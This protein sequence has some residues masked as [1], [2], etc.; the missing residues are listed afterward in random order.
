MDARREEL[1]V[2]LASINVVRAAMYRK[3]AH[4]YLHE[5]TQDELEAL[6]NQSFEGLDGGVAEI[7]EGYSDIKRALANMNTGTRQALAVDYAHTFLAAGNY[8]TYAA[9][10]YESVFT[11]EHGLLMQEARDEVYKAYCEEHMQPDPDLHIPEDHI[12][13]EFEFLASLLERMNDALQA[14]DDG[15]ALRYARFARAF[16][17][18]HQLNWIDDLAETIIEVAE[19]DFYRGL[20]KVTRG[21]VHQE[22]EVM[23]DVVW[24]L[25]EMGGEA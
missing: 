1:A 19:T 22:T 17:E 8:E 15:E 13:F 20:A 3:L 24:A 9:T 11:S 14:Q 21:F 25:E 4:L 18:C 5:C 6:S 16:H 7:A 12:A 2:Q 23:A 10:P